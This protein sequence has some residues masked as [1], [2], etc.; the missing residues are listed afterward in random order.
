MLLA[1]KGKERKCERKTVDK[2]SPMSLYSGL[3]CNDYLSLWNQQ[4]QADTGERAVS[5][6]TLISQK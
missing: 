3:V 4:K 6:V 1:V 5:W 2:A